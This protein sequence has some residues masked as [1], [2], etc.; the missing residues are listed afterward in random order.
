MLPTTEE[1]IHFD[2]VV[3]YRRMRWTP[4]VDDGFQFSVMTTLISISENN[5]AEI[6]DESSRNEL[7]FLDL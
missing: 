5:V 7:N 6:A 4:A 2:T 1:N 3:R